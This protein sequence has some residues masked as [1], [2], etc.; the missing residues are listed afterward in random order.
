MVFED[1]ESARVAVEEVQG[2]ELFDKP[3]K[4]ALARSRSDKTVALKCSEEEYEIHKRHRQAEK[5]MLTLYSS[6]SLG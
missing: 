6:C 4:L 3:M 2:F 5:G 1:P